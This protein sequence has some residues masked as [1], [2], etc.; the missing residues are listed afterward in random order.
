MSRR[1][2]YI[3][4]DDLAVRRGST[5]RIQERHDLRRGFLECEPRARNPHGIRR[6]VEQRSHPQPDLQRLHMLAER[7]LR[8][9]SAVRGLG[10]TSRFTYSKKVF[11]PSQVHRSVAGFRDTFSRPD[12]DIYNFVGPEA[13]FAR[14]SETKASGW[15]ASSAARNAPNG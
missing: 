12:P 2:V 9:K 14:G 13:S 4:S 8:Q 6:S 15:A 10:K 5:R 1:N 7:G 11:Q 3:S